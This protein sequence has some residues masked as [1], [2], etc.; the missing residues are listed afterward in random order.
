MAIPGMIPGM[1]NPALLL[2]GMQIQ[3]TRIWQ[4]QIPPPEAMAQF[5][6]I[7]PG[8]FDR[9]LKMAEKQQEG[10]IQNINQAQRLAGNDVQRGHYLGFALSALAIVSASWFVHEHA[11]VIAGLC[12]GVPVLAVAKALIDSARPGPGASSN[13]QPA[14]PPAAPQG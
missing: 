6:Q 1:L 5:E 13:I 11:Q 12:L 2:A 4:G 7:L 9:I 14:Q 3:Q 10:Q 8:S